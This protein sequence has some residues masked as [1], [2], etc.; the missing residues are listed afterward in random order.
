M[1]NVKNIYSNLRII[2][3]RDIRFSTSVFRFVIFIKNSTVVDILHT[4]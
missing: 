3:L 2:E 4:L 1:L